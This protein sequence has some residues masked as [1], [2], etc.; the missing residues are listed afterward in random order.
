MDYL[1]ALTQNREDGPEYAASGR[2]KVRKVRARKPTR[3]KGN[4]LTQPTEPVRLQ[5]SVASD[6]PRKGKTKRTK[7]RR[8]TPMA[9][10]KKGK[11]KQSAKAR[12]ASLRNLRKARA[13][14]EGKRHVKSPR[15]RA[16]RS[17]PR[18]VREAPKRKKAKRSKRKT[19]Y[20]PARI[21][22]RKR[23][24]R[25]AEAPKGKRKRG[26][27]RAKRNPSASTVYRHRRRRRTKAKD[28]P[29]QPI[30]HKRA[31]RKGHGRRRRKGLGPRTGV[32]YRDRRK[33]RRRKKG[34]VF[35]KAR[36]AAAMRNIARAHGKRRGTGHKPKK[37]K[38][39]KAER[40][41]HAATHR[42]A[43]IIRRRA[44]AMENPLEGR[45]EFV[46]NVFSALGG[47]LFADVLDRFMATH[48]LTAKGTTDPSGAPLYADN[49][50]TTGQYTGLFNPTAI[51]APLWQG[52]AWKRLG[53]DIVV[54]VGL[55]F[56]VAMF[57][58]NTTPGQKTAK[59]AFTIA[60]YGAA[61]R[62]F[63]KMAIDGLA[64]LSMKTAIG[65]QLY[66]GEMRASVL[67]ANNGNGQ[68]TQLASLPS[69]GLGKALP[70]ASGAGKVG[71]PDCE[72]CAQQAQ[73]AKQGAGAGY[74]SM[75]REVASQSTTATPPM[76]PPPPVASSPTA[77]L[78][79][80]PTIVTAPP[81]PPPPPMA[82]SQ[83]TGKP[84]QKFNPFTWGAPES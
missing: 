42:P 3:V 77:Q 80:P 81:P 60:G 1:K 84:A 16:R 63:G 28:W 30:R 66:D 36:K 40:E 64:M 8:G 17:K 74:P 20:V 31:A 76:P 83:L 45:G 51:A 15:R 32:K 58:K 21:V 22:R 41:Y 47:F 48:A 69:A 71:K 25:S 46:G 19:P 11:R 49:P 43:R 39:S 26:R 65:Q 35:T 62:I 27:R 52:G 68:A 82:Q 59:T 73:Q 14:R 2:H 75:P 70:A 12:A 4:R 13:A 44:A 18:K 23:R 10:R 9:G 54:G 34:Y 61:V 5:T 55:P 38:A 29:G 72:P 67:A 78:N 56:G 50:P 6:L 33:G 53:V 7:P 79:P 37:R 57:I 24:V